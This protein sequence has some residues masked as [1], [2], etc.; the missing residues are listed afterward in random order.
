MHERIT[1]PLC[2]ALCGKEDGDGDGSKK[3]RSSPCVI[4]NRNLKLLLLLSCD[5]FQLF[6]ISYRALNLMLFY[7]QAGVTNNPLTS[8]SELRA[9]V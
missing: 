7:K 4:H 3:N 1:H 9:E 6:I 8:S 5:S 2:S